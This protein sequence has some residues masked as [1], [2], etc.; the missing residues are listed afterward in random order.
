M[1]SRI[2]LKIYMSKEEKDNVKKYVESKGL[3]VS[4]FVRELVLREIHN[5][6]IM[7]SYSSLEDLDENTVECPDPT[8]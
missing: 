4:A 1:S 2:L 6:P 7:S 3:N 8:E 5:D